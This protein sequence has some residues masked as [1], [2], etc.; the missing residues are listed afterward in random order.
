MWV[1]TPDMQEFAN[2]LHAYRNR[3]E[4]IKQVKNRALDRDFRLQLPYGVKNMTIYINC[5]KYRAPTPGFDQDEY[6]DEEHCNGEGNAHQHKKNQRMTC[7]FSVIF[8]KVELVP[9]NKDN[10]QVHPACTD[11]ESEAALSDGGGIGVYY[12]AKFRAIHNHPLEPCLMDNQEK[13]YSKSDPSNILK[14]GTRYLDSVNRYPAENAVFAK[15]KSQAMVDIVTG[16]R[17]RR[18]AGE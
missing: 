2:G 17:V 6:D 8:K 14:S 3:N 7:P 12:L 4:L 15:F 16:H 5:M 10:K 13:C 9:G 1:D 11:A 18:Q